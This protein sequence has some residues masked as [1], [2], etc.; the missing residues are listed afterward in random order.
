LRAYLGWRNEDLDNTV[1]P[2]RTLQQR[3]TA[4][5]AQ[6]LTIRDAIRSLAIQVKSKA[7]QSMKT[8][9][10]ADGTSAGYLPTEKVFEKGFDP[11]AG[12]FN[13]S[14]AHYDVFDQWIEVLPT[15]QIAVVEV[16]YNPKT[17][18]QL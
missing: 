8:V 6:D 2:S 4:I 18:R 5:T 12:G 16:S 1:T 13:A 9:T 7:E 10:N 14:A 3:Y 17:G 11:L 15:D